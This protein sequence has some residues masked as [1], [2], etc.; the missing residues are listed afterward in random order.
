MVVLVFRVLLHLYLYKT[1]L[2]QI[3]LTNHIRCTLTIVEERSMAI[4]KA[5]K[6][7]TSETPLAQAAQAELSL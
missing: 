7:S 5:Y 4:S 6:R 3:P 2:P 1:Y